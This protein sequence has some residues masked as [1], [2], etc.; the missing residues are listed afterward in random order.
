MEPEKGNCRCNIT[1]AEES[2]GFDIPE[3]LLFC[4]QIRSSERFCLGGGRS[5]TRNFNSDK[6]LKLA[7]RGIAVVTADLNDGKS[8]SSQTSRTCR[9]S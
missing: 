7:C 5:V 3:P 8:L 6:A 9:Q 1:D 2:H 4:G